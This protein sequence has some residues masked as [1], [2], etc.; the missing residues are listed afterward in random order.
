M[1]RLLVSALVCVLLS[2]SAASANDVR[3]AV[4][5]GKLS[6]KGDA[7]AN[8]LTIDGT[9]LQSDSLRITPAGA[10]TVN[11]AAGPQIFTGFVEGVAIK[12]GDGNDDL[13]VFQ[14][15]LAG[16]VAINLGK[17]SDRLR[18]DDATFS[19]PSTIDLGGGDD[20]FAACHSLFGSDVTLKLG[21]GTS[22]NVQ[23]TC[24]GSAGSVSTSNASVF[25]TYNSGFAGKLDVKAAQGVHVGVIDDTSI[26][27][28]TSSKNVPLL[29]LCYGT[30]ADVKV[31]M[32]KILGVFG[33]E[34]SCEG[35]V[36][37]GFANGNTAMVI[38]ES[39]INGVLTSKGN[40]G[41]DTVVVIGVS[42]AGAV[43]MDHAAGF[44][45]VLFE[46]VAM[47]SLVVKAGKND[48]DLFVQKTAVA[49]DVAIKHGDGSNVIDFAFS[50]IGGN[51]AVKTGAGNDF[52]ERGVDVTGTS[53]IDLGKGTNTIAVP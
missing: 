13:E 5:G 21:K 2:A 18:I 20:A 7:D 34:V 39:L 50:T 6:I 12:L 48:D 52:L 24:G 47:P 45:F 35:G 40:A 23:T 49:G 38:V 51:L 19:G 44:N 22:G 29:A 16:K 17:G 14:K 4:K 9:G 3:V 33:G 41:S 28:V 26:A 36:Q 43:T 46:D 31:K 1:P 32:P 10:T 37:E 27:G 11:G 25:A 53:T 8:Q 42:I 15:N 30:F